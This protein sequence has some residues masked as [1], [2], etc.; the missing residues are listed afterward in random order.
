MGLIV[1][2]SVLVTAE[3]RGRSVGEILG[4]LRD[5][6]GE[7]QIGLSVVTIVE[8][9]HGIPR[10]KLES[11]RQRRQAFVDELVADVPVYPLTTE[12]ARLAGTIAGEQREKGVA[13]PFE[14]LL[15]GATALHR[16]F[17]V[18][19]ENRRHFALIPDLSVEQIGSASQQ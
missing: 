8:L 3:R 14:D 4:Q 1:D 5:T 17:G 11:Q 7:Q 10:A 12:I 2:P 19:T 13:I 16:G 15:I 9:S 18:A 6:C